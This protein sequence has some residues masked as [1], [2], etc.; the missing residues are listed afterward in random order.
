MFLHLIICSHALP[1][2]SESLWAFLEST[3]S[4]TTEVVSRANCYCTPKFHWSFT[5]L[6]S[7]TLYAI[8]EQINN[9][10]DDMPEFEMN[11]TFSSSLM[12]A[13]AGSRILSMPYLSYT[14]F[15]TRASSWIDF[16]DDLNFGLTF[17]GITRFLATM[18]LISKANYWLTMNDVYSLTDFVFLFGMPQ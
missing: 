18:Q 11:I 8:A 17:P 13:I 1:A 4:V 7:N 12:S 5:C 16:R 9:L 15:S 3:K 2:T 14:G 6:E 10:T